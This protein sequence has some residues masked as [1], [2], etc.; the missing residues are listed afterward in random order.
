MTLLSIQSRLDRELESPTSLIW[1]N[2]EAVE[3]SSYLETFKCCGRLEIACPEETTRM[4]NWVKRELMI[5][6]YNG[7]K[8][9]V[10]GTGRYGSFTVSAEKPLMSMSK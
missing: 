1:A 6:G 9:E 7:V 4:A 8:A 2:L 10:S 3:E 5:R